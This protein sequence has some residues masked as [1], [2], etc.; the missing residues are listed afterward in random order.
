MMGVVSSRILPRNGL[1][2]QTDAAW[3]VVF[4]GTYNFT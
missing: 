3:N 2:G 1:T 4:E